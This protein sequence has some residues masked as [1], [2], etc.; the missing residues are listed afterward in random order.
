V[1]SAKRVPDFP[2]VPTFGEMGLPELSARSWF[3]LSGPPG[4]HQEIVNRLTPK[5]GAR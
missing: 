4:L 1:S 5:C 3:S 2:T